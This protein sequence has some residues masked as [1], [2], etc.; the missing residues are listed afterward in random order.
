MSYTPPDSD[1]ANLIF[2]GSYTPP[3]SLVAN[4]IFGAEGEEEFLYQI[5]IDDDYVYAVTSNGL[6]IYDITSES[7]YAYITYDGGFSTLWVN[8]DYVF[9]GT[10]SNGVKY[11]DKNSITGS[12]GSPHDLSSYLNNLGDLTY[13]S[14]LTSDNIS[15][16]HGN[17]D[18][19]VCTT[20]VGVDVVKLNPQS[21]R[22]FTLIGGADKCFMSSNDEV[23]YTV[24]SGSTWFVYKI[25]DSDHDWSSPDKIYNIFS[26]L[27]INDV[28]VDSNNIYA[29]TSSGVYVIDESD[30]SYDVYYIE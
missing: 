25:T 14:N 28:F 13:Y 24:L 15:Y 29:A 9:L 7:K 22:S 16:I 17:D 26:S 27:T 20:T 18:K 2:S 30:D 1:L 23:Y 10:S 3:G 19:I 21:Y 4:L 11:L 6:D 8:D 5:S 12:I